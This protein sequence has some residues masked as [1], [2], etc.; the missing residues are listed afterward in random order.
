ML[1]KFI[2]FVFVVLW[3][4][5]FVGARFGLQYAEPATLVV[6]PYD[7]QC[8]LVRASDCDTQT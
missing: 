8:P 3:S 7:R 5:G 6:S 4:S 2:P 1:I